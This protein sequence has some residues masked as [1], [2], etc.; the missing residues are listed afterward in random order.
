MC[1]WWGPRVDTLSYEDQCRAGWTGLYRGARRA[2][3]WSRPSV[4]VYL[5]PVTRSLQA[6]PHL[7]RRVYWV[8]SE[9]PPCAGV[10][11]AKHLLISLAMSLLSTGITLML[12][13]L[14]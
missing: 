2:G 5:T 12:L 6:V 4:T 1:V 3:F 9:A 13:L 8:C 11:L 10:L 14:V 7:S